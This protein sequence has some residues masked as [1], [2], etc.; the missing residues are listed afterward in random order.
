MDG[1]LAGVVGD[2]ITDDGSSL[3]TRGLQGAEKRDG[4]IRG[5]TDEQAT[6]RL[7]I[8][9]DAA[10]MFVNARGKVDVF[11]IVITVALQPTGKKASVTEDS[12]FGKDR[13]SVSFDGRSQPCCFRPSEGH[14]QESQ[15]P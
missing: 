11:C 9:E 8:E 15:S 1:D 7:R 2:D 4:F 6:G 3:R 10:G 13:Q 14:D 12:G 5:D